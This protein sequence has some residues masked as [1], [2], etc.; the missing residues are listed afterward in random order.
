MIAGTR[1]VASALWPFALA[2][3]VAQEPHD[4]PTFASK[5]ELVTVDAV[6]LDGKGRPVRG[7]TAADFTLIEDGKPQTIASFEAIDLGERRAAS[8]RGGRGPGGHEHAPQR[9]AARSFVLL[10]DD[11][12]LAPT[13]QDVVRTAIARFLD[14]GLRDGDELIFATTSGDAWWSARMPEGRE[15]VGLS[16]PACGAGAW[17]TPGRMRSA[18]GRPIGS[19][20]SKGGR[21]R[22]RAT[23][24]PPSGAA[25]GRAL[26]DGP[27]ATL[28]ERVV[29]RYYQR[30]VCIPR[31]RLRCATDPTTLHR[32]AG[33]WCSPAAR[34][35]EPAPHQPDARRPRGRGPRGLRA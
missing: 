4:V 5:V 8:A 28:T 2:V 25:A 21:A 6:V 27:G 9:A 18:S 20:A 16:L 10:V 7:L 23:C 30:R 34:P 13:R 1:L 15:D 19:R 3:A 32:S 14:T 29:D 12:S 17:W 11:M 22:P 33:A 31:P 26:G 24:P 35:R